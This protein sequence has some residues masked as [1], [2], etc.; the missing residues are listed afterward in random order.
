MIEAPSSHIIFK[1][2]KVLF[3]KKKKLWEKNGDILLTIGGCMR[4]YQTMLGL[5][6]KLFSILENEDLFGEISGTRCGRSLCKSGI[7]N[8]PFG[9][10]E[11]EL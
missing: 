3:K 7:F 8:R 10:C 9:T 5:M 11:T 4:S 2:R 6:M 1:R